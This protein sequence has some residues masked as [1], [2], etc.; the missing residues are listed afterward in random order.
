MAQALRLPNFAGVRAT[1]RGELRDS[2]STLRQWSP[3]RGLESPAW[4]R[5]VYDRLSALG[6]LPQGWDTYGA[7]PVDPTA[8]ATARLFLS[9]LQVEDLPMPHLSPIPTGGIGFHWRVGERDLEIEIGPGAGIRCLRTLLPQMRMDE[10]EVDI[11][12][13]QEVLAWLLVR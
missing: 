7:R 1:R 13:A 10:D 9:H 4:M 6:A 8:L 2:D 12:R 11:V 5:E 3:V